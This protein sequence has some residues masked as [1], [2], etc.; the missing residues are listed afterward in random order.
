MKFSIAAL[1]LLSAVAI[2]APAATTDCEEAPATYPTKAVEAPKYEH[3]QPVQQIGDGQ[4]QQPKENAP[5]N[6]APKEHAPVYEAPKEHAPVYEAPKDCPKQD[7]PK[8]AD[9]PIKYT[10][11]FSIIATPEQ[12]VQNNASLTNAFTGGLPGTI[13]YYDFGLNSD[14]DLICYNIKIVGFQGD[15]QSPASTS[16][17]LHQSAAGKSGPPRVSFPNPIPVEGTNERISVGC[18]QGPFM[19]G[20]IS[21]A[22][23]PL[24]PQG[25]NQDTGVGFTIAML[26]ANPSAYNADIHSTLAV[27]GAVRGQFPSAPNVY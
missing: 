16:T 11:K 17:H 19:T 8:Q 12:V 20:L 23:N 25:L 13:G 1:S 9:F 27:P 14:L 5:V 7:C 3:K 24:N 22:T 18:L 21:N 2:A 4:V 15:Y 10:S 6:E 26:E